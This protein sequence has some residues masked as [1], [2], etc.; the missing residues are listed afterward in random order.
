MRLLRKRFPFSI[1]ASTLIANVCWE[2]ARQ[3]TSQTIS[4]IPILSSTLEWLKAIPSSRICRGVCC[5]LWTVH[6]D[7]RVK[8]AAQL[9]ECYPNMAAIPEKVVLDEIG[10]PSLLVL[11]DLF[12]S[13]YKFLDIMTELADSEEAVEE[14]SERWEEGLA[15][16]DDQEGVPPPLIELAFLQPPLP[17]SLH[18]FTL[19]H[20]LCI[21]Q[22][23]LWQ[24]WPDTR[25][26]DTNNTKVR[27]QEVFDLALTKECT[28]NKVQG[29]ESVAQAV[30]KVHGMG[31]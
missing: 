2:C 20:Q 25:K 26:H 28:E 7:H 30:Q 21:V 6:L 9:L 5:L 10:L 8:A 15:M 13:A 1:S 4:D 11:H 3:I 16:A 18:P 12:V 31:S 24:K 29:S 22:K 27:F 14:G 23:E 17:S 19:Y